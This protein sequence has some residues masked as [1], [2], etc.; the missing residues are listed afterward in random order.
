MKIVATRVL[1]LIAFA[2]LIAGCT[3]AARQD[4]IKTTLIATNAARD[5]LLQYDDAAQAKIVESA[6][7][8]DDGKKKLAEYR[9]RRAKVIALFPIVYYSIIAAAQANDDASF[10]KMKASLKL[11]LD[12]VLPLIGGV[13]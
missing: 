13:P 3:K 9:E 1:A 5:A 10:N 12:A 6:T 8:L 2:A 4:T 11:L 7:S